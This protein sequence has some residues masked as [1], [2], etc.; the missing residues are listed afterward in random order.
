[1]NITQY[2]KIKQHLS[3]TD[4]IYIKRVFLL[5]ERR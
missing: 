4:T 3:D 2:E 1:M 5:Y